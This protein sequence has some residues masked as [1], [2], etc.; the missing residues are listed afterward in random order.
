[1][2]DL[3]QN[4]LLIFIEAICCKIFFET[5]GKI[6]HKGWINIIQVMLLLGSMCLYSY[7]LSEYFVLRQIIA[8]SVFS[9]FMLW[10]IKISLKKSFI[11]AILFDA[12]LLAMDYL[13]YLICRWF[14]LSNESLGQQYD[15]GFALV[16]LLAKVILFFAV[17]IIRKRFGKKS[18]EMMLDTEWLRFLFFPVFIIVAISAMLS[19]FDMCR[20]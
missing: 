18:I 14:S 15:I 9:L 20:Q 6:R 16:Y 7:A 13:I 3:M 1:M 17:L 2:F 4:I 10:H 19:V 11:L 5:F 12:L 8:I